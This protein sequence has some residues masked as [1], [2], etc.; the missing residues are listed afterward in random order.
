[1]LKKA[2]I[3]EIAQKSYGIHLQVGASTTARIWLFAG[4]GRYALS[5][6]RKLWIDASEAIEVRGIAKTP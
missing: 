3:R 2:E 1:M 4:L 6:S 5:I